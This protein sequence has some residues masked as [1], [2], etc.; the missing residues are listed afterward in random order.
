MTISAKKINISDSFY[1]TGI[2]RFEQQNT[3]EFKKVFTTVPAIF[4]LFLS[5]SKFCLKNCIHSWL[6]LDSITFTSSIS[7]R[8]IMKK[9]CLAECFQPD[10]ITKKAHPRADQCGNLKIEEFGSPLSWLETMF[11]WRKLRW[12]FTAL[13]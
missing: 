11:H 4:E 10:T 9:R 3:P 12:E 2:C 1:P 6:K 8:S 5:P 7:F 13:V